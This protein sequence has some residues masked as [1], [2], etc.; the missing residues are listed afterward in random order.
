MNQTSELLRM[1]DPNNIEAL[2]KNES[3][4]EIDEKHMKPEVQNCPQCL[5]KCELAGGLDSCDC[6]Y[7]GTKF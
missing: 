5:G 6:K 1:L 4:R 2:L 3:V 7:C